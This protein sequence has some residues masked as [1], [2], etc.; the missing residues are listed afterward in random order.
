MGKCNHV[1][2]NIVFEEADLHAILLQWETLAVL[3]QLYL[4]GQ[5]EAAR[6]AQPGRKPLSTELSTVQIM[7]GIQ[8]YANSVAL[9]LP[10]DVSQD[11]KIGII[12]LM[13]LGLEAFP[14]NV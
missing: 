11:L 13:A 14:S 12:V 9:C 6:L 7:V 3:S 2:G 10:H 1:I 4:Q 8:D 5:G